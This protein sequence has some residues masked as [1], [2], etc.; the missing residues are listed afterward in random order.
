MLVQLLRLVVGEVVAL[1]AMAL[2]RLCLGALFHGA[3]IARGRK[4]DATA[5]SLIHIYRVARVGAWI[6]NLRKISLSSDLLID[7]VHLLLL[8]LHGLWRL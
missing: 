1:L 2:L 8:L 4:I 3:V 5:W 7:I 6:N